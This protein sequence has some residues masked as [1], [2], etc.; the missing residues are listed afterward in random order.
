LK[1]SSNAIIAKEKISDYLLKWQPD[2]DK[3]KF[4]ELA[5]YSAN[6]WQRLVDDIRK[7]ILP[8]DAE[9]VRKTPYGDL[10]RI[11][12]DLIG[13]NGVTLRVVTVWMQEYVSGETKFITLFP[14][15]ET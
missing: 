14:D 3:S 7:Q 12:N 8:A 9:T 11:R 4:L 10:F 5:G 15:K 1:I 2:N 13:P 6:D